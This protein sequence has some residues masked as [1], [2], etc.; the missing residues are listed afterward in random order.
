MIRIGLFLYDHL[1]RRNKL[2]G[3]VARKLDPAASDNPLN[4]ASYGF[5]Y[6]DCRVDDARLV[7]ANAL[8]AHERG[9]RIMVRT[10]CVAAR[11]QS[12][13]WHVTLEDLLTGR[14]FGVR[15]RALVN[16][17]G[18]WAQQ[19]IEQQLNGRSPRNVRLIKGSH[20]VTRK[21]YEG[22]QAYI[23]QNEDKRIVF[24]IPYNRDFTLVG[25]TD[26]VHEGSPAEVA[27]DGEEEQ[28]LLDVFNQHF[29]QQLSRADILWRYSGVRPLCDD[30]SASPSA[31]TRDYTLET[32]ADA[33]D[34]APVLHVFG[35]KLTTYRR[36]A[37]A[38]LQA[39]KPYFP[40]MAGSWTRQATLPGG[41]I[42]SDDFVAWRESLK[43]SYAWLPA[44]LSARLGDAY[45][46][47][48]H[49]LLEHCHSMADL[50]A[51]FGGGL[52]QR[53]V[54]FLMEREWARS[55]DDILWRRSKLGLRLNAVQVQALDSFVRERLAGL[56]ANASGEDG[57]MR[58][59]G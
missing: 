29:K 5:E 21:L 33:Q 15:A 46:S 10:R 50:G 53:E 27:M 4:D 22:E 42:G 18:P 37:E 36:L 55:A 11:R 24:V 30:E 35:G 20:L 43:S 56:L 47:R 13:L 17:A 1:S 31:I 44:E 25:T 9:A 38:A 58:A 6:S 2:A 48:V 49:T 51:H 7:V 28:Y 45:G 12:G 40:D 34:K 26:K 59:A 23:L 14:R 57:L 3:S 52:H 32:R 54:E 39:L 41:D 16:A 19:L 8:A